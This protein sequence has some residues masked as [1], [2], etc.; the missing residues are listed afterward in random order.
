MKYKYIQINI[1]KVHIEQDV[2]EAY[3]YFFPDQESDPVAVF[4][5]LNLTLLLRKSCSVHMT[6]F[7]IALHRNVDNWIQLL[8]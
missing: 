3:A 6:L 1:Y 7:E 4:V 2:R 5:L 8:T